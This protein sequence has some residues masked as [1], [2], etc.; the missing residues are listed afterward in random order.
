MLR[1]GR[2]A[3]FLG[4]ISLCEIYYTGSKQAE[5]AV[6]LS[7]Q[8]A[9]KQRHS[10]LVANAMLAV[11][12]AAASPAQAADGNLPPDFYP[13]PKCEKPDA[14][15]VGGAPGVQDQP[16]MLAY[17]LKVRSYNKKAQAFNACMKDYVDRAQNDINVIQ[18]IVHA[19]VAEANVLNANSG[20]APRQ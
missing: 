7:R 12:M 9:K 17:N 19:A 18:A 14:K 6:R 16:A 15:A 13:S 4:F 10:S 8:F 2:K 11:L 3:L 5:I 20:A 1:R